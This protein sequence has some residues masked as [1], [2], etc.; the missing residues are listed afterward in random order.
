MA[1]VAE[2]ASA[3]LRD[4]EDQ[5]YY[6]NEYKTLKQAYLM[7]NPSQARVLTSTYYNFGSLDG[8]SADSRDS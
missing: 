8:A 4:R 6:A 3:Y 7:N 5:G 1:K 2:L